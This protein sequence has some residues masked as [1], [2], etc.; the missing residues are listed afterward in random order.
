[1]QLHGTYL[2]PK[3]LLGE[4]CR[5]HSIFHGRMCVHV[6]IYIYIYIHIYICADVVKVICQI[7]GSWF[8]MAG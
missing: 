6:R 2:D 5:A 3:V 1:M 4:P 7:H 8:R